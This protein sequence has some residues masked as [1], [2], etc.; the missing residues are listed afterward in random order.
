MI[1]SWV[2]FLKSHKL[3][4]N[5]TK[6]FEKLHTIHGE[7][8][9]F[10]KIG[11]IWSFSELFYTLPWMWKRHIDCRPVPGIRFFLI[12]YHTNWNWVFIWGITNN[13][14]DYRVF[15][16]NIHYFEI[17]VENV[18]KLYTLLYNWWVWAS[19]IICFNWI[20]RQA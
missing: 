9:I 8:D 17:H 16:P 15:Y 5:I 11:R 12:N 4:Q 20:D 13:N 10:N 7:G 1:F 2:D 14:A 19:F 3:K 6:V 18:E